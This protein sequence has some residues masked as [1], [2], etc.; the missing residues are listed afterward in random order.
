[1]FLQINPEVRPCVAQR[2]NKIMIGLINFRTYFKTNPFY[3]Y[4][5]VILCQITQ[6]IRNFN[7]NGPDFD[8]NLRLC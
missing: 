8:E 4:Y 3:H 2:N 5:R 7:S 6:N 1:M